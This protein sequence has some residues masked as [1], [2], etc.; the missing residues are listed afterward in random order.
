MT[1]P[2]VQTMRKDHYRWG[3]EH[4]LWSGELARWDHEID[5]ELARLERVRQVLAEHKQDLAARMTQV[6]SHEDQ[7]EHHEHALVELTEDSPEYQEFLEAHQT[8][9]Q[10]HERFGE[11]QDALRRQH[12]RL[13]WAVRT[14]DEV[15]QGDEA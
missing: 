2:D 3:H 9:A 10:R 12:Y 14:L 5:E 7:D 15:A 13:L 6:A 4:V 11:Q 1:R 8:G